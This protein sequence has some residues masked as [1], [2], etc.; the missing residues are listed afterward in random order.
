MD[1][2]V[3]KLHQRQTDSPR[4]EETV[5]RL[6]EVTTIELQIIMGLPGDTPDGFRPH[7]GLCLVAACR[8]PRLSLPGAAGRADDSR[9]ARVGYG[10]RSSLAGD[11]VL[12]RLVAR[13]DLVDAA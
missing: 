6:A 4:F 8:C 11:D 2:A 7:P 13:R 5:R 1:P 9:A 10:V 12:S 3:L